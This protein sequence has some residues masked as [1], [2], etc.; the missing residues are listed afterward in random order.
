MKTLLLLAVFTALLLPQRSRAEVSI[1][2]FYDALD[3]YGQW[4]D[5]ADY[6]YCWQPGNVGS[7]WRPYTVGEWAYTD[8][9]WTWAS[10]EPFG[11]ATYHYGRWARL[12]RHGW[13]WVPDSRWG[14][15]WVSWRHSDR[16]TGWAPLP[17]ESRLSVGVSLGGWVDSY[18]DIGP[19]AYSFVEARHF[20]SRRLS[21]VIIAPRQNVTIINQT[22]NVTNVSIVNNVVV[23]NGPDYAEVSRRAERPIRKLRLERETTAPAAGAKARVEGDTMRVAAPQISEAEPKAKPRKVAQKVEQAEV[24]TGWKD[25]GATAEV[26]ATREKVKAEAKVPENLPAKPARAAAK[27]EKT[28]ESEVSA[29]P[30]QPE[31]RTAPDSPA[32]PQPT[33]TPRATASTP[34]TPAPP[35]ATTESDRPRGKTAEPA[36]RRGARTEQPDRPAARTQPPQPETTE[37]RPPSAQAEERTQPPSREQA[38]PRG[39]SRKPMPPERAQQPQRE[40]PEPRGEKRDAAPEKPRPEGSD[41][42]KRKPGAKPAAPPQS[43]LPKRE[44]KPPKDEKDEKDEKKRGEKQPE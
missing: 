1:D 23:N 20:G 28:T 9:G 12:S 26:Q 35:A 37:P 30:P 29:R 7:D 40:R 15:A 2:F 31:T 22:R 33:A 44:G 14:P 38:K 5:V 19:T 17:P 43:E 11:W 42:P 6:G 32:P 41:A 8:A 16:H 21:D 4:I 24:N 25:A 27:S 34:P 18:Y 39:E 3:P 13:I 10:D 36:R